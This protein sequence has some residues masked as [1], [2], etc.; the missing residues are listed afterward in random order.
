MLS[1]SEI[2]IILS[3][4]K[5]HLSK[6]GVSSIGLFGSFVRGEAEKGSDIDILLDFQND[7]ETYGNFMSACDLLEEGLKGQKL[8]IVTYKGLSPYIG[9]HILNEV[10]YV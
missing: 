8:D 6:Y 5:D 10:I 4:L 7:K 3:C 1:A 2:L 9:K